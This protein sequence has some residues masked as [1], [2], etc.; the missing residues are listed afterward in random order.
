MNLYE[1][2]VSNP[3]NYTDP[4][5]AFLKDLYDFYEFYVTVAEFKDCKTFWNGFWVAV[6]AAGLLP[7]IPGLAWFKKFFGKKTPDLYRRGNFPK[8]DF[9]GNKPKGNEWAGENP[10]TTEDYPKKYGLPKENS[11]KTPDF[12]V[13]G[14]PNGPVK[15]GK[16]PPSHNAPENTGG[17]IEYRTDDVK[18]EWFHMP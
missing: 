15:V 3:V 12:V 13:K 14:Q 4:T 8:G 10:L 17:G 11:N 16:A 7:L 9:P 18:L 6:A 1:Y 5:G 2:V